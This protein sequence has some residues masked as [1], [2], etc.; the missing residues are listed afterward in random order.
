[1]PS[2]CTP[3]SRSARDSSTRSSASNTSKN[4]VSPTHLDLEDLCAH[5]EEF[6]ERRYNRI[7]LHSALGHVPPEEFEQNASNTAYGQADS[8]AAASMSFFRHGAIYR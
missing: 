3:A 7:R 8:C 6:I 1:M 2:T 5:I 4:G